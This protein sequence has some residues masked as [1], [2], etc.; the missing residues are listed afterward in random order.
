MWATNPTPSTPTCIPAATTT[1][2]GNGRGRRLPFPEVEKDF[3]TYAVE[4]TKEKLEFFVDGKSFF[5]CENDG[6]GVDSWPFD[7]PQYLILNLA[8]GGAWG[9]QQGVDDRIF[10]QQFIIDYVRVYQQEP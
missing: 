3:H 5:T 7:A 10:P 8:I 9:G 4:W 1:P 6:Q 2:R